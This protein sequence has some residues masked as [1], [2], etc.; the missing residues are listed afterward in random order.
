MA[1]LPMLKKCGKIQNVAS[2]SDFEIF[3][4]KIIALTNCLG[5]LALRRTSSHKIRGHNSRG[6]RGGSGGNHE[7]ESPTTG[8]PLA[9]SRRTTKN[10]L[11]PSDYR[12]NRLPQR[13]FDSAGSSGGSIT[14]GSMLV[15]PPGNSNR[16]KSFIHQ[17]QYDWEN[18]SSGNTGSNTSSYEGAPTSDASEPKHKRNNNH[19]LLLPPRLIVSRGSS[20]GSANSSF[21][22]NASNC[23]TE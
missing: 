6:G 8:P 23:N 16:R 14:G 19:V 22:S 21:D 18:R 15:L 1:D 11:G 5:C 20:L 17:Y 7:E 12:G 9:I 10:Y 3:S 13:S 4:P 2:S